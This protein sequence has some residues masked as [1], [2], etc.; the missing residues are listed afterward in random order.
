VPSGVH[1]GK[2]T[3]IEKKNKMREMKINETMTLDFKRRNLYLHSVLGDLVAQLV[4]HFTF[5]ERVLGS[6][7][8]QVTKKSKLLTWT[9]F[10]PQ[11]GSIFW[12]SVD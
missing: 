11:F 6:N 12:K 7:P 3:T 10:M 1:F 2:R 4:E 9:F 5:N 8:S